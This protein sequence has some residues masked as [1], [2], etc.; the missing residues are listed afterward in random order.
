MI[1]SKINVCFLNKHSF[2]NTNR[3]DTNER[4]WGN[5]D[6]MVHMLDR[7]K[8]WQWKCPMLDVQQLHSFSEEKVQNVKI[9]KKK[10]PH[11]CSDT[12]VI[13]YRQDNIKE[14]GRI[15]K[16]DQSKAKKEM[17]LNDTKSKEKESQLPPGADTVS[18]YKHANIPW[19]HSFHHW[20]GKRTRW[21]III[22]ISGQFCYGYQSDLLIM[23]DCLP[24]C[25]PNS[26]DI[27]SWLPEV[28]WVG[29]AA[30]PLG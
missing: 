2:S 12:F 23:A 7:H 24:V 5:A 30:I 10:N 17:I 27:L 19:K 14:R 6:K 18:L 21:V 4:P 26:F 25:V 8:K 22:V 11:L 9:S 1:V 3:R 28:S 13:S 29:K 15:L 16:S 20:A